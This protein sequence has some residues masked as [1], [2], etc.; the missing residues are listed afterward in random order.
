MKM[1]L[2]QKELKAWG[3]VIIVTASGE[4]FELHLGDTQFDMENRVIRLQTPTSKFVIDGDAIDVV[5]M[6]LGH[7]DS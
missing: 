1:E 2:V 7:V 6:H 5:E 4:K 3:E